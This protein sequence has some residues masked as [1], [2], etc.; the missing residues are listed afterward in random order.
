MKFN[1]KQLQQMSNVARAGAL[2]A[3]LSAHSGHVGIILDAAEMITTVFAN[4][5]EAWYGR[6]S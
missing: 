6:T 2:S 4:H 1:A 3:V 5:L